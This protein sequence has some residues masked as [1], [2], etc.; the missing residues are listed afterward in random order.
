MS[1]ASCTALQ[2]ALVDLLA[3]WGVLAQKVIGHSSGE[4]AAAYAAGILSFESALKA[5]YYRGLYSSQV[6]T[7][8][9]MLAVGLSEDDAK[10]KIA[11]LPPAVG[12]A[13]VACVNSPTNTTISGDRSALEALFEI[14]QGDGVFVRFLKVSIA[15]HSDHMEA[16][17]AEYEKSLEGMKVNAVSKNIE[18][19]STVTVR[20]SHQPTFSVLHTGEK[21]W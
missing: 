21:T 18:M 14:L 19:I 15:Y 3:S 6:K 8:G 2:V 13:F 20:L 16:A 4:I 7:D 5:A 9:A 12:K 1:Q 10:E 11:A 17:A